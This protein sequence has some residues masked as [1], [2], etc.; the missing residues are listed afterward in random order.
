MSEETVKDC[1]YPWTWMLVLS[2]GRVLPC[3]F[4]KVA[5]GN[6]NEESAADIWNGSVAQELRGYVK[7]DRLHPVCDGAAC[8]FAENT[9][10]KLERGP[11]PG[12]S[13]AS[14]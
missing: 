9:K 3:C 11:E 10:R 6:L 2:D 14:G 1:R 5:L 4:A 8:R 13:A 12:P 7:E